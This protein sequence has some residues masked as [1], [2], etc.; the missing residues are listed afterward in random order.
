MKENMILNKMNDQLQVVGTFFETIG[1]SIV[2]CL[3]I[4]SL[5]FFIVD[6][7]HSTFTAESLLDIFIRLNYAKC[8]HS[9][10]LRKRVDQMCCVL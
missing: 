2:E 1:T 8:L 4:A 6:F 9:S 5:D 3:G 7:E 10:E